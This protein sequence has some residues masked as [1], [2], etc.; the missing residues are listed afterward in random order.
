MRFLLV[1][2]LILL[3]AA[4]EAKPVRAAS[5]KKAA[6]VRHAAQAVKQAVLVAP[7]DDSQT[8]VTSGRC[9]LRVIGW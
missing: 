5:P 3:G 2:T 4:V 1:S 6:I 8:V 7:K 9:V